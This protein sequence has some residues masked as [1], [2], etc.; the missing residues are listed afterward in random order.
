[1]IKIYIIAVFTL[2]VSCK[3]GTSNV[4]I[5]SAKDFQ[6]QKN[7]EFANKSKSPL[8]DEDFNH[9]VTLDFY[10]IAEKFIINAKFVRTPNEKP[11]KMLTTTSRVVDYI[12]FGEAHFSLQNK[13]H[14]LDI[15][16]NLELIKKD[17]FQ[18]HLFLPFM[19]VTNGMTTYPGGRYLDLE[20]PKTDMISIDFNQSYN[21]YCAYNDKYSC[22][23]P[24]SENTLKIAIEAGVKKFH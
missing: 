10:P 13:Q 3:K 18:N 22:P 1:M 19:D 7:I 14:K 8:T 17:G 4:A 20:Q 2:L 11:F 12:K 5:E 9:F 23:I 15:Y 21:P 6:Y 16:Q 24:P